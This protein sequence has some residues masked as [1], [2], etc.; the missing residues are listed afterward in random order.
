MKG[1]I[2]NIKYFGSQSWPFPH[3]LMLAYTANYAGGDI[4]IDKNELEDARWFTF[5]GLRTCPDLLP[6]KASLSRILLDNLIQDNI[7][8]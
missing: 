5:E 2:E 4:I 6:A 1:E 3:S 7:T 8:R